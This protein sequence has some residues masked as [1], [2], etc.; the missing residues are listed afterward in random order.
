MTGTT[1]LAEANGIPSHGSVSLLHP[2]LLLAG[3]LL[4]CQYVVFLHTW[5]AP[6]TE[7]QSLWQDGPFDTGRD[8]SGKFFLL[9]VG[10]QRL[11]SAAHPTDARSSQMWHCFPGEITTL[12]NGGVWKIYCQEDRRPCGGVSTLRLGGPSPTD[13]HI[14]D[15]KFVHHE[16]QVQPSMPRQWAQF[17]YS[18]W[19][20]P[21][22]RGYNFFSLG[23]FGSL[24]SCVIPKSIKMVLTP[25]ASTVGLGGG[26]PTPLLQG[27]MGQM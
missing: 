1:R 23:F 21:R 16:Y 24:P 6:S 14:K 17:L 7:I 10:T 2:K 19:S 3:K 9:T 27:T 11:G 12:S 26:H 13:C 4:H 25:L 20:N 15:A 22:G 8:I 5:T 18:W